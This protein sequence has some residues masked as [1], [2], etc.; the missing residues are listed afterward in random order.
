MIVRVKL[1]AA[2]RQ[3]AERDTAEI[4]LDEGASVADL[5]CQMAVMMPELA[6]LLGH[7][8]FAID[9]EYADD[10]AKILAG[11]DIACIPPVSGG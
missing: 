10:A 2:A 3:I 1:F 9:S 8:L 6:S 11:A 5:R 4:E 7:V